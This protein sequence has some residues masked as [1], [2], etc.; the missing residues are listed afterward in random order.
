MMMMVF[1]LTATSCF[2]TNNVPFF[3]LIKRVEFFVDYYIA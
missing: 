2:E 1:D 3:L